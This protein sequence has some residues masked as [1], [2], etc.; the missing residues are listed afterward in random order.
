MIEMIAAQALKEVLHMFLNESGRIGEVEPVVRE[1]EEARELMLYALM[2]NSYRPGLGIIHAASHAG[3]AWHF[4]LTTW[5][6]ILLGEDQGTLAIGIHVP[7]SPGSHGVVTGHGRL[8]PDTAS[9]GLGSEIFL[10]G[11]AG[12]IAKQATRFA[13][14]YRVSFHGCQAPGGSGLGG[15]GTQSEP[16]ARSRSR[17]FDL[18]LCHLHISEQGRAVRGDA[19]KSLDR[20]FLTRGF[21]FRRVENPTSG[22]V[23]EE[24]KSGHFLPI[25]LL[26]AEAEERTWIVAE[27]ITERRW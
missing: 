21:R 11:T 9:H 3:A 20:I 2:H 14:G 8:Q 7:G 19:E 22:L 6:G 15:V 25:G 1:R 17:A 27:A 16:Q 26:G 4:E 18:C 10:V 13:A 5:L 23:V 12:S 24:A